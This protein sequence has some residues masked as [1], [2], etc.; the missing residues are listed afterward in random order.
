MR[1]SPMT[2]RYRSVAAVAVALIVLG[3]VLDACGS[4]TPSLAPTA[5]SSAAPSASG[6]AEASVLPE[7]ISTEL[8][9]GSNRYLFSFIDAKANAP[10]GAPDRTA[11]VGFTGP[12]SQEIAAA[13]ATFIWAIEGV[14]GV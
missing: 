14:V 3:V 6:R 11:S 5:V 12:A 10:V 4:P 2:L 7:P 1:V 9:V 8:A 13:P